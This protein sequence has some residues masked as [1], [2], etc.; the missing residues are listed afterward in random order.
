MFALDTD[1]SETGLCGYVQCVSQVFRVKDNRAMLVKLMNFKDCFCQPGFHVLI[2]WNEAS[3][4]ADMRQRRLSFIH[5]CRV[6]QW[7]KIT[8]LRKS[9]VYRGQE[10]EWPIW[11]YQHI[12]QVETW[13]DRLSDL[14]CHP[15]K[16]PSWPLCLVSLFHGE[17]LSAHASSPICEIKNTDS[18][19][20]GID[21]VFLC[22]L[23]G[24]L[25]NKAFT[26]G[27]NILLQNVWLCYLPHRLS[28]A[29]ISRSYPCRYTGLLFVGVY[30]TCLVDLPEQIQ[31]KQPLPITVITGQ[32]FNL[33]LD[34]ISLNQFINVPASIN[35]CLQALV[36][37]EFCNLWCANPINSTG[38]DIR[39]WI[40]N[41]LLVQS[42]DQ[43]QFTEEFIAFPF[44]AATWKTT[45][46][47]SFCYLN[48]MD[49]VQRFTAESPS[50]DAP[51]TTWL[52][53]PDGRGRLLRQTSCSQTSDQKGYTWIKQLDDLRLESADTPLQLAPDERWQL[54]TIYALGGKPADR[55]QSGPVLIGRLFWHHTELC[56]HLSLVARESSQ[57][58]LAEVDPNIPCSL[59]L[60]IG[61]FHCRHD[62]AANGVLPEDGTAIALLN[63]CMCREITQSSDASFSYQYI[64]ANTFCLLEWSE[65]HDL[66]EQLKTSSL[67][68]TSKSDTIQLTR[69]GS[70]HRSST[71]DSVDLICYDVLGVSLTRNRI[72]T[73]LILSGPVALR[74]YCAFALETAYNFTW[75]PLDGNK[76]YLLH[77]ST[78]VSDLPKLFPC[79]HLVSVF[80]LKLLVDRAPSPISELLNLQALIVYKS[81]GPQGWLLWLTDDDQWASVNDHQEVMTLNSLIQLFLPCDN[82]WP[83]TLCCSRPYTLMRAY[84]IQL[85]HMNHSSIRLIASSI[86]RI[87]IFQTVT[88]RESNRT[89]DQNSMVLLS[90]SRPDCDICQAF[91]IRVGS[92]SP[93]LSWLI[94]SWTDASPHCIRVR[95]LIVRCLEFACYSLSSE[96]S[97]SD[98]TETVRLM[99]SRS[100]AQMAISMRFMMSDGSGIVL[101]QLGEDH[102]PSNHVSSVWQTNKHARLLFGWNQTSW[103]RLC[104]QLATI[105]RRLQSPTGGACFR[106]QLGATAPP[107]D[108]RASCLELALRAFLNSPAFLRSHCFWLRPVMARKAY[109]TWR[110]KDVRL[111]GTNVSG[112]P[113]K[114]ER[115]N[116]VLPP[117]QLYTL[118][119]LEPL[120]RA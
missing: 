115:V 7:V 22:V 12:S 59:P 106:L 15:I 30:S 50:N 46:T 87:E 82:P 62:S 4:S 37:S 105:V 85:S 116:I 91:R 88:R 51:N 58:V 33:P 98:V 56:F 69:L 38:D 74:W 35:R 14:T 39:H 5:I 40:I 118:M 101:V 96:N 104:V 72:V 23:T 67:N 18:G 97:S 95:G 114:P 24:P 54:E 55:F 102:A 117:F 86:S 19:Q 13:S 41:Q 57:S 63:W 34:S 113:V 26:P 52:H 29:P 64:V 75:K 80:Q 31:L 111:T 112:N 79:E 77:V 108:V 9:K 107:S 16:C 47:E 49:V 109:C 83:E 11:L 120:C 25:G 36:S 53:W 92:V 100:D 61:R 28:H 70:P 3:E 20:P 2:R 17:V 27:R 103:T 99:L 43:P 32:N 93:T 89:P 66:V 110:L 94:S 44:L 81:H 73:N 42:A 65:D 84:Q 60:V 45:A 90:R 78:Q 48:L 76:Q 68:S 21:D 1:A 10:R 119:D 8:G 6:R 71:S